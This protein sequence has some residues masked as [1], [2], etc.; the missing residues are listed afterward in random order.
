MK[1]IFFFLL[2]EEFNIMCLVYCFSPALAEVVVN[3]SCCWLKHF[4]VRVF[5][6][7]C[8]TFFF[9]KMLLTDRKPSA[10]RALIWSVGNWKLNWLLRVKNVALF[11]DTLKWYKFQIEEQQLLKSKAQHI[12]P[13]NYS[14]TDF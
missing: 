2:L 14:L 3:Y 7:Q 4:H 1:D 10:K 9:N 5:V 12:A 8:V 6:S 13:S 11:I